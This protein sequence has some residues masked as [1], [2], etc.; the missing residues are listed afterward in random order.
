MQDDQ[1]SVQWIFLNVS[2]SICMHVLSC[3]LCIMSGF[4]TSHVIRITGKWNRVSSLE[5]SWDNKI[6]VE[7]DDQN[8]YGIIS[9]VAYLEYFENRSCFLLFLRI[10]ENR[11]WPDHAISLSFRFVVCFIFVWARRFGI[12]ACMW[13][14]TMCSTLKNGRRFVCCRFCDF[15]W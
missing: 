1:W 12:S 13:S 2:W 7:F 8:K 10:Q 4:Y 5:F 9:S 11:G 15:F 14:G 3:V 6:I